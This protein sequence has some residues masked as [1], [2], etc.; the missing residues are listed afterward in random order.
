MAKFPSRTFSGTKQKIAS[1]GFS[2]SKVKIASRGFTK[3]TAKIASR[4]FAKAP[5]KEKQAAPARLDRIT[6]EQSREDRL[7]TLQ[8]EVKALKPAS[9]L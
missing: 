7:A 1:R 5:A 4:G 2:K 8:N 3:G 6:E 9:D